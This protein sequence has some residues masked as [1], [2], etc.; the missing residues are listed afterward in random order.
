[1]RDLRLAESGG[2][3]GGA[4]EEAQQATVC[5]RALQNGAVGSLHES[6]IWGRCS[7]PG[8]AGELVG[9]DVRSRVQYNRPRQR[10]NTPD[11]RARPDR[12][13]YTAFPTP[14]TMPCTIRP[15][16]K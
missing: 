2:E 4:Q 14:R 15:S 8:R 13:D 1:M 5:A 12:A 11:R 16:S 10:R 3:E 6:A 7:G 9:I